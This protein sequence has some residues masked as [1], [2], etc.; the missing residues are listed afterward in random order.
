MTALTEADRPVRGRR[1]SWQ[2]FYTQRPDLRPANDNAKF[3]I[4]LN[5][6]G[7]GHGGSDDGGEAHHRGRASAGGRN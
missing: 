1:L 7:G 4:A 6:E 5:C 3:P 2:A